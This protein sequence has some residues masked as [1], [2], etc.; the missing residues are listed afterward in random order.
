MGRFQR[1]SGRDADPGRDDRTGS[2]A[3]RF[4]SDCGRGVDVWILYGTLGDPLE[5][6]KRELSQPAC[7]RYRGCTASLR[8]GEL[9]RGYQAAWAWGKEL[10]RTLASEYGFDAEESLVQRLDTRFAQVF[11]AEEGA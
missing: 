7:Q 11:K 5:E 3:L 9:E 6:C 4:G 8:G 10:A 2:P 1:G